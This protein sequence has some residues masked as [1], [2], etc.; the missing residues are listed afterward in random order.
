[1][2]KF[3]EELD[4][5][6]MADDDGP[7]DIDKPEEDDNDDDVNDTAS[8]MSSIAADLQVLASCFVL[9]VSSLT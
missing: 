3:N 4:L 8:E 5:A 1:M 7:M 6:F 9:D 2:K